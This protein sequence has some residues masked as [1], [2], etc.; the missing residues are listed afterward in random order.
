MN[1]DEE[2]CEKRSNCEKVSQTCWLCIKVEILS[3]QWGIWV[4]Y[5]EDD[6]AIKINLGTVNIWR[7]VKT[8]RHGKIANRMSR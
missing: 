7:V 5:D 3:R 6:W 4:E 8:F 1:S 2:N